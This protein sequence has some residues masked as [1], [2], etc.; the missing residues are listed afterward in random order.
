MKCRAC[1]K[2]AEADGDLCR[3]HSEARDALKRAYPKWQEAYSGMSWNEYLN[4]VKALGE[5]GQWIKEVISL[6]ETSP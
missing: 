2:E 1:G 3:R 6:E 5:T 4:R